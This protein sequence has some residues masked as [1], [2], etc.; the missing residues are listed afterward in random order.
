MQI[1]NFL[2]DREPQ[3]GAARRGLRGEKRIED[4]VQVLLFD[5]FPLVTDFGNDQLFPWCKR[6]Q[7]RLFVAYVFSKPR[8]PSADGKHP[9]R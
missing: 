2:H 4:L 8:R 6:A 5:A 3:S 7:G 9:A 1:D